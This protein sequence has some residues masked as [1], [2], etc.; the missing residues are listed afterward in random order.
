MERIIQVEH[1]KS[2]NTKRSKIQNCFECQHD[3]QR[4]CSLEHFMFYVFEFGMLNRGKYSKYNA[5]IPKFE[6]SYTSR[7]YLFPSISDKE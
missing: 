5:M 7:T 3:A 1:L 2:E 6:K 4:E